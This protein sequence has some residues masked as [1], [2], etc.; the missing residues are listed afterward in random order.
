MRK[1][2]FLNSI[3]MLQARLSCFHLMDYFTVSVT[4]CTMHGPVFTF[5]TGTWIF[6]LIGSVLLL[7]IVHEYGKYPVRN[8]GS[9]DRKHLIVIISSLWIR[10]RYV[11]LKDGVYKDDILSYRCWLRNCPI[12]VDLPDPTFPSTAMVNGLPDFLKLF[13]IFLNFFSLTYIIVICDV[14]CL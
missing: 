9:I 4:Y 5:C 10:P 7:Q 11:D 12:R 1:V 2:I 8:P 6:L 14:I 13:D 3:F